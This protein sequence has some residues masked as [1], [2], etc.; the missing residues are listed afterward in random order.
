M[1]L[2]KLEESENLGKGWQGRG[3][4]PLFSL[5]MLKFKLSVLIAEGSAVSR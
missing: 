5:S 2:C 1:M 3:Y 4:F